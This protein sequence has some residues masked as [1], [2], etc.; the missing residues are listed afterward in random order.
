ML[1]VII[2][3]SAA[4]LGVIIYFALSPKSSKALRVTALIAL[5][6][7]ILSMLVCLIIIIAGL[8]STGKEPVMPDFLAQEAPPAAAQGNFFILFLLAAFLLVFLGVVV[9]LSL[10]ERKRQMDRH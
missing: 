6:V 8:G 5:G 9:F 2:P 10:R 7:I 4:L 1:F 3:L